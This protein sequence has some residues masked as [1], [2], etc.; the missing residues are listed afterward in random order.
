MS[1]AQY[2][3]LR[4]F[5]EAHEMPRPTATYRMSSMLTKG[6][7]FFTWDELRTMR[8]L[9]VQCPLKDSWNEKFGSE[10]VINLFFDLDKKNKA[11][12]MS[13]EQ[14]E[15]YDT[16]ISKQ[17]SKCF[18]EVDYKPTWVYNKK[19]GN[20][21]IYTNIPI[22]AKYRNSF[23]T[24]L[25]S[26]I[27]KEKFLFDDK[28]VQFRPLYSFKSRK[29]EETKYNDLDEAKGSYN[30]FKAGKK[31]DFLERYSPFVEPGT[32]AI[33]PVDKRIISLWEEA[34]KPKKD[35]IS[36]EERLI[37]VTDIKPLDEDVQEDLLNIC[38]PDC[39][40]S[41]WLGLVQA[42]YNFGINAESI[43]NWSKESDK[44]DLQSREEIDKYESPDMRWPYG[45]CFVR[46]HIKGLKST[47]R[48]EKLLSTL[49]PDAGQILSYDQQKIE[50]ERY[51]FKVITPGCYFNVEEEV[52]IRSESQLI[53]SYRHINCLIP[54]RLSKAE[55]DDESFIQPPNQVEKI[56]F[57][58]RWIDDETIRRYN[59]AEMIPPPNICD[60]RTFNL[61]RGFD[62]EKYKHE[63][64]NIPGLDKIYEH[65]LRLSGDNTEIKEYL[66]NWIAK[67]FQQ[68]GI[69][70]NV[71]PLIRSKQ[72]L[73][74]GVFF[75]FLSNIIGKSY[76]WIGT[77]I[78]R[79]VVGQFNHR[80]ENKLL[81]CLDE[82]NMTKWTKNADALKGFITDLTIEIS[83]KRINQRSVPSYIHSFCF[84]N[85][86]DPISI[87]DDDRRT[88]M[89]DASM[90][91]IPSKKIID[92]LLVLM[93]SKEI[94]YAFYRDMLNR[95]IDD[96]DAMR[97][98]VH[99]EF[100]EDT[101]E[102]CRS[103][104]LNFMIQYLSSLFDHRKGLVYVKT[105][106]LFKDFGSYVEE[107]YSK[108]RA[109]SLTKVPF[110]RKM[111]NLHIGGLER[112]RTKN[113]RG[114]EID[115]VKAKKWLVEGGFIKP[116]FLG[117]GY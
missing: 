13:I 14:D 9:M 11:D 48:I 28:L 66:L 70:P 56:C 92:D 10:E 12:E 7:W 110:A 2:K 53:E 62:V 1:T 59:K 27:S 111:N 65:I 61:W 88:Q 85:N 57:I 94:Q 74:K 79:E 67:L 104:E 77:T 75:E 23:S 89:I 64:S 30:I 46:K 34:Q 106:D 96:W 44:Y 102:S 87:S 36:D 35:E 73:G 93:R 105:D 107:S 76:C 33:E 103:L 51:N 80:M 19:S 115:L 82:M 4:A 78:E 108:E 98:R 47:P 100:E 109:L 42:F 58:K 18:G 22:L 113:D 3:N 101:K 54:K 99:T 117:V 8:E 31:A 37:K 69:K 50:F 49:A 6:E 83:S 116:Q 95:N 72:G 32:E 91:N 86:D 97:N 17:I 29:N 52:V 41:E 84:S 15:A 55:R 112:K 68:P 25:N 21:R 24:H 81:V 26:L 20:A 38:S 5:L 40:K 60:P 16:F 43:Q 45:I 71:M 114:F 63:K 90:I 39:H